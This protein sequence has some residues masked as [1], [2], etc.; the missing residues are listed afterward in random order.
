MVSAPSHF[1]SSIH[2]SLSLFLSSVSHKHIIFWLILIN[3]FWLIFK[4]NEVFEEEKIWVGRVAPFWKSVWKILD[5]THQPNLHI[6]SGSLA[7]FLK[8]QSLKPYPL[9]VFIVCIFKEQSLQWLSTSIKSDTHCLF[10]FIS[11]H[12][13]SH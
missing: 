1:L 2:Y 6:C 8:G 3:Y 5:R 13:Y 4:N 10:D 7:F 9:T 11:Y 12:S